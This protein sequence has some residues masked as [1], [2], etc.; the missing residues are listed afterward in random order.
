M[1]KIDPK[2][3]KV[4]ELRDELSKRKLSTEGLKVEL[5]QRLQVE[6]LQLYY[7]ILLIKFIS[8]NK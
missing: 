8:A 3:L 1:E 2:K 5:Q 4:N 6:L 7:H